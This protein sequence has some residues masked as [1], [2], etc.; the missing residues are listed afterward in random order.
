MRECDRPHILRLV[1]VLTC[2]GVMLAP[3]RLRAEQEPVREL[4]REGQSIC[5]GTARFSVTVEPSGT[6]RPVRV[7]DL[8]LVSF[9]ALYTYPV[10]PDD[11]KAVRGCQAEAPGLGDRPPQMDV[12]FA[13]GVG[14][15][16]ITRVCSHPQVLD[17]APLWRLQ[18]TIEIAPDGLL[19]L[20]YRCSFDRL[21]RWG[22]FGLA[23]ALA[24]DPVRGKTLQSFAPDL[25]IPGEIPGKL[26]GRDLSEGLMGACVDSTKGPVWLWFGGASR[27]DTLDWTQF[28]TFLANPEALPHSGLTVFR[29]TECRLTVS[30]RLPVND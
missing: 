8:P 13:D 1:S 30:M 4:S 3:G 5:L 25:T 15:V 29:G 27:V 7:K 22:G 2:L 20:A 12:S 18:E 14:R 23:T 10:S 19:N 6:I 9:I 26:P 11:G 16:S 24:M 28:L 21:L 17:N